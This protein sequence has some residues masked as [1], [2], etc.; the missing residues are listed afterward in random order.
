MLFGE[1]LQFVVVKVARMP[2]DGKD[3]HLPIIKARPSDI[4]S[5]IWVQIVRNQTTEALMVAPLI[6]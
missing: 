2:N 1:V 5:G 4:A 6:E 3:D